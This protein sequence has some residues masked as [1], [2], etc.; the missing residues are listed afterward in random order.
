MFERGSIDAAGKVADVMGV[1][2]VHQVISACVPP[3]FPSR[4]T[5]GWACIPFVPMDS[6][7]K[8]DLTKTDTYSA[9]SAAPQKPLYPLQPNVVNN[10]AKFSPVRAILACTF[11]SRMLLSD[12]E[13]AVPGHLKDALGQ[14]PDTERL[15]S[16]FVLEQ[17]ER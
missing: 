15:F 3:V 14:A 9:A 5:H 13:L 16:E 1:D 8:L 4:S 7:S 11:G 10:L 6:G 17:S 2:F 12:S